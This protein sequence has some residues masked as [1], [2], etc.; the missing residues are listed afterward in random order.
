LMHQLD[1][2]LDLAPADVILLLFGPIGW[3]RLHFDVDKKAHLG[4]LFTWP[5]RALARLTGGNAETSA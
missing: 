5:V 1:D 4:I 3:E 2:P